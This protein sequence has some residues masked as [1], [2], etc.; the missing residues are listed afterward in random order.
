MLTDTQCRSTK[1]K[2][3]PY[4]LAD[5]NGLYLEVKPN[6]IKAWR[7][8]FELVREGERKES[9]FAIGDYVS[10]PIGET[11]EQAR[12]RQAGGRFTLSEARDERAKARALVKQ[13]INPAH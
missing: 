10:A 6:G 5:G 4:K 8:R 1:A 11:K 9:L 2:E 7:Y 13:G 12:A 3:K